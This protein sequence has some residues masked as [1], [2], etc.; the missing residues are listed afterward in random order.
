MKE[1]VESKSTSKLDI[2]GEGDITIYYYNR[3]M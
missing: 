1:R 2:V 3:I